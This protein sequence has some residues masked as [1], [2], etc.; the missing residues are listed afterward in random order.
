MGTK[1]S[2][3]KLLMKL[4]KKL[5]QRSGLPGLVGCF[6]GKRVYTI[7]LQETN[8]TVMV[9]DREFS[10]IDELELLNTPAFVYSE[11]RIINSIKNLQGIGAEAEVKVLFPLKSFSVADALRSMAGYVDGF[12]ASS[13]FEAKLARDLLGVDKPV[14]ITTPCMKIDEVPIISELC[15]Y[16]SFN[17]L[18]QWKRYRSKVSSKAGCGLRVNPELAFIKDDRYNPCRKGSKLGVPLS[19]LSEI[20]ND[21][22]KSLHEVKG[23]HFHTNCES[24]DF[25]QLFQTVL[26]IDAYLPRLLGQVN[27]VNLGGGYLFEE[28]QNFDKLIEAIALLR[29]KYDVE[30]FFEPGKAIVGGAGYIVSSVVDMFENDGQT[31]AILDTSVNHMPEVFEYSYRPDVMQ[32]SRNGKYIYTLA[33]ATCLAGDLFGEYRFDEPLEIGS[34]ITFLDMGSYTLVKAHMFN[35]VNLPTIYA[36]TLDGKLELKKQFDYKDYKSRWG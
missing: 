21:G 31:I 26:H 3:K 9:L 13:L 20:S 17:S 23:L 16:I 14:H 19:K 2:F 30:V 27:W 10:L 29:D 15:D 8:K 34:R 12:S 32:E 11:D 4:R 7:T 36:Y 24:T 6:S 35:G 18:S 33:G 25:G 22:F 5:Q 28:G 1:S